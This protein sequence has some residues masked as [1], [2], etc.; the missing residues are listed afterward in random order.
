MQGDAKFGASSYMKTYFENHVD[1]RCWKLIYPVVTAPNDTRNSINAVF[2]SAICP[3]IQNDAVVDQTSNSTFRVADLVK[4]KTAVFIFSRDEGSVY[5]A[6]ITGIID[7]FY[8][9]LTDMAEKTGGTLT[10]KVCFLLD[11]FGNLAALNNIERKI[12]LSRA[13]GITWHIVCQSL[14][15]LSLVY[16]EKKA[17]IILGNCNN[18]VYLY[19]PDIK[20]VKYISELC[21]ERSGDMISDIKAPLCSVNMLRHLDK[22]K[23]ECL[24][25]L[26]RMNPF[27]TRLPDISQYYGIEP[28]EWI[29]LKKRQRQKLKGIDFKS[30]VE[31]IKRDEIN[32]KMEE[33]E[34]KYE[35]SRRKAEEERRN[36]MESDSENVISIMDNVI[37]MLGGGRRN[38]YV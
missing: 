23:G 15:Q 31:K 8:M 10:R 30:I 14:D 16:G 38:E 5:D 22:D 36:R 25:L 34:K 9:L 1:E 24:M 11:E 21:G 19:S 35:E 2:T 20:L 29:D 17:P 18:I 32:R 12:S 13:R 33:S 28:I 4:E 37:F 27:I 6:L 3:F 26:E 7:Q